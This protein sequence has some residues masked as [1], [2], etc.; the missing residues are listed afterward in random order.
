MNSMLEHKQYQLLICKLKADENLYFKDTH[1]NN[2]IIN[3]IEDIEVFKEVY[4]LLLF[5]G[6][7]DTR[8]HN[9]ILFDSIW[10]IKSVDLFD[11][12]L[13]YN[14]EELQTYIT[15]STIDSILKYNHPKLI[16]KV[17]KFFEESINHNKPFTLTKNERN[18][19]IMKCINYNSDHD[20]I[21]KMKIIS[22]IPI[23]S[24]SIFQDSE[25][26]F[27][28]IDTSVGV[29]VGC[30]LKYRKLIPIG[31]NDIKTSFT[32][33]SYEN[34]RCMG[35][36][37]IDRQEDESI[38]RSVYSIEFSDMLSSFCYGFDDSI[39]QYIKNVEGNYEDISSSIKSV[40]LYFKLYYCNYNRES[41]TKSIPT[42]IQTRIDLIIENSKHRRCT[43]Y[44]SIKQ[45]FQLLIIES[46]SIVLYAFYLKEYNEPID[47]NQLSEEIQILLIY[48]MTKTYNT[49]ILNF[50][51]KKHLKI[52]LTKLRS[53][54]GGSYLDILLK[55]NQINKNNIIMFYKIYTSQ[56]SII[57][58]DID[59]KSLD[60][61]IST[62]EL[63]DYSNKQL[64]SI[65]GNESS[66]KWKEITSDLIDDNYMTVTI[67]D[68]ETIDWLSDIETGGCSNLK[69]R[70]ALNLK[71]NRM[72]L[73]FSTLELLDYARIKFK[74]VIPI[75]DLNKEFSYFHI[76]RTH[77]DIESLTNRLKQ[78]NFNENFDIFKYYMIQMI[79]F[80]STNSINGNDLGLNE[81]TLEDDFYDRIY[82][83]KY[84]YKDLIGMIQFVI[85]KFIDCQLSL[86]NLSLILNYLFLKLIRVK[87]LTIDQI[88]TA[89]QLISN[90][91][92]IDSSKF[93][94]YYY[95]KILSPIIASCIT[96]TYDPTDDREEPRPICRYHIDTS[97]YTFE[98]IFTNRNNNDLN[99]F[100]DSTI[101]DIVK[102]RFN[103]EIFPKMLD[104][105]NP[106]INLFLHYFEIQLKYEKE[107]SYKEPFLEFYLLELIIKTFDL[108]SFIKL[109]NLLQQYEIYLTRE[110]H[111]GNSSNKSIFKELEERYWRKPLSYN[112][113]EWFGIIIYQDFSDY[114]DIINYLFNKYKHQLEPYII[115]YKLKLN[116]K[117]I[118]DKQ[119]HSILAKES[120]SKW[121][122]IVSNLIDDGDDMIVTIKDK[123]TIDWLSDI[124]TGGCRN[125]KIRNALNSK[126]NQ[127]KLDFSTLELLE[128]ARIKFKQIIPILDL[129]KQLCDIHILH[130]HDYFESLI[131]KLNQSNFKENKY[132]FKNFIY[133]NEEFK[134]CNMPAEQESQIINLTKIKVN[135]NQ[136]PNVTSYLFQGSIELLNFEGVQFILDNLNGN[137]LQLNEKAF[138]DDFHDRIYTCKYLYKD[139]IDIIQF[140]IDKF[141]DGQLS[142]SNLSLILNYLYLKL[143]RVNDLTIDQIN[144][145]HQLIS[146][147][148]EI[149]S[150]KYNSYYYLKT[151]SPIIASCITVIED[152]E[153]NGKPRPIC[154]YDIDTSVYTFQHIFTN[155]NNNDLNQFIDSTVMDILKDS[156]NMK[157]FSKMLDNNNSPRINLFLHSFEIELKRRKENHYK[158]PFLEYYLLELIIKTFDLES[159][160][161]LDN[162]LQQYE[163]DL[164]RENHNGNCPNKRIFNEL[165]LSYKPL[166]YN[167]VEWFGTIIYQDFSGYQDIINYLFNKY[168]HQ[169]EPYIIYYKLKL[170]NKS[171]T[172]EQLYSILAK[173]SS[174]KWKEITSNLI[175]DSTIVTIKDKETINWL[176]NIKTGGCSNLK[177]REALH[178][179]L[180]QMKL[181]FSSSELLDY[182]KIKFKQVIPI[183]D[184]NKEYSEMHILRTHNDIESLIN[185]LNQSNFDENEDL[186]KNYMIEIIQFGSKLSIRHIRSIL[187]PFVCGFDKLLLGN[188]N[189]RWWKLLINRIFNHEY[190]KFL[191]NPSHT[192]EEYFLD[193][194]GEYQEPDTPTQQEYQIINLSK[195][196]V[197]F[198][199]FP[200]VTSYL[201]QG[202]V[203]LL[204]F[205]GVQLILDNLNGND[206]ELNEKAFKDH[207]HDRIYTCKYVSNDLYDTIRFLIR[208]FQDGQLS[209]S[210]LS[211]IL[212]YLFPKLIRVNNL[213][214]DQ[215]NIA[216]QLISYYIKI[217][218][219]KYN[220]YYY[221]KILSPI[222]ASC[223]TVIKN[224]LNGDEKPRLSC[225]YDIDTSVYTFE[226]IFTN[227]NNNDQNQFID[228]TI[229]DIVKDNF[230]IEIFS[231]MLD[232]S[233]PRIN[234]FLHYFEMELKKRK[235]SNESKYAFLKFKVLKLIIK[236]FDLESFIKFEYLLQQYQIYLSPKIY[237]CSDT[238]KEYTNAC[239]Q[240]YANGYVKPLS[241]NLVEWFGKISFIYY[242]DYPDIFNYL[243]DKYK[244]QF[245]QYIN[246]IN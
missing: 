27:S 162:L 50:L 97:V 220:S 172:D 115:Y 110:N 28:S 12:H 91:I 65:L 24:T 185:N 79:Q 143:I 75:L 176:S 45:L 58:E 80:A 233:N 165:D 211:L 22:K 74:Q 148:I 76:L 178:S 229:M 42:S 212:N 217:E 222:I 167:M 156:F 104:N 179:K 17:L 184:L 21:E 47:T 40:L 46:K 118:T 120:S 131:V 1:K 49:D 199:H 101:M 2:G 170:N 152:T 64:H 39:S 186:F 163:I 231:K 188:D 88:K 195:I 124:E 158:I 108:E 161:K 68:K 35:F 9:D 81:K 98:H 123:E 111:D 140:L 73:E 90:Y 210:N 8:D 138:K 235:T 92:E 160:I 26:G 238:N 145:A 129:N 72:K 193:E 30:F 36:F 141:K 190:R 112:M 13:K 4:S 23:S 5:K 150:S 136:F 157:I 182:A 99:Q 94:S 155:R 215:I 14:P 169:L 242:S 128:Y 103:I 134:E 60:D 19:F 146:N 189:Y 200:N 100:I 53:F 208:K 204:N 147:Y 180:N 225:E 246:N 234:L 174:S 241:S 52:K 56:K 77:D 144:V 201:F 168:K 37:S 71:L 187:K 224:P 173:E 149:D 93:T 245:E 122:E 70:D 243:F 209:L 154:H 20:T 25:K 95:L 48:Y 33:C 153:G 132:I 244:H 18:H 228:S 232:N 236:T 57:I 207:Y 125:L 213:T 133:Q 87:D 192:Y 84:L 61:V 114:Q 67:K 126:L 223:I 194:N 166:S 191:I 82:T 177:I 34:L 55:S 44:Q 175:D 66:S 203:E 3:E 15:T 139:L 181:D 106:R 240:E 83:C 151:L 43:V 31:F 51:L 206:L 6:Y 183:L 137:D 86:S 11:I 135:F 69:I 105:N 89:Y 142:L 7:Q 214:I 62:K 119:L 32:H 230:T 205:E 96:N 117:T 10:G 116:N 85:D 227:R 171:I 29:D 78:L 107:K 63:I 237:K 218:S 198:N 16:I 121:K 127:M 219:S 221:L 102:D 164:T 216:Y 159:F 109:D 54:Y 130:A 113:V 239:E 196:K 38:Q 226:H 197:N 41:R 59:E 202:S